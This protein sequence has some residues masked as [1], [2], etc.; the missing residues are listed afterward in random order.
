MPSFTENSR[1]L[2]YET[3]GSGAPLLLLHGFTADGTNWLP[4]RDC[5]AKN[6][7]L[8]I[9]D[10]RFSGR[11]SSADAPATARELADDSAALLRHLQIEKTVIAGH[12]M[13]GYIAQEFALNYPGMTEKLILESTAAHTTG[14][15]NTLFEN[16][17]KLLVLHGYDNVFWNALYAWILPPALYDR[18]QDIEATIKFAREYP[19]LS[20]A[21]RIGRQVELMKTFDTRARLAELSAPALVITGG[22][23]ILIP[24]AEGRALAAG[25]AGAEFALFEN[26]SHVPHCE[27]PDVFAQTVTDFI[28]KEN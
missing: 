17:H 10:N 14:R 2:Y 15:N 24:A 22:L 7:T 16:F 5:L 20:D 4:V 21:Q 8:I 1:C 25:I 18:P 27:M 11:S 3:T 28:L 23:D 26:A 19:H 6:F 13:G 9:P 12:S